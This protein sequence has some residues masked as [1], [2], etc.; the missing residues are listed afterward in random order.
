MV[1]D[2]YNIYIAFWSL[3][4]VFYAFSAIFNLIFYF[5]YQ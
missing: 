3:M 2:F 1:S 5:F 4:I